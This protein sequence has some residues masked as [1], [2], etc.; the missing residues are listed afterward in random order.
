MKKKLICVIIAIV[1]CTSLTAPVAALNVFYDLNNLTPGGGDDFKIEILDSGAINLIGQDYTARIESVEGYAMTFFDSPEIERCV[2]LIPRT[3]TTVTVTLSEEYIGQPLFTGQGVVIYLGE[4]GVYYIE[5]GW[6]GYRGNEYTGEPLVF[7]ISG[8]EL[9]RF[10]EANMDFL[11]ASIP[12]E[13]PS[14]WAE[15]EVNAAIAAGL[16][17]ANLQKNYTKDVS[18]GDVA[19]MFINLIEKASGQSIDDFMK[20]KGVTINNNAFTDT[21]NKAVLAANALGIINGVGNNKF[22]PDGILSRAQIAAIINRVARV[23]GVN[24]EGYTH[25]FTDVKGHWVDVEL[26]WPVHEEII[27]GVGDNKFDPDGNLTTEQAIAITY[28]ALAPLSK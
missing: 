4:D 13:K 10:M 16:V 14:L 28:R 1:L 2:F 24:T 7:K 19:Q 17:P 12:A 15:A 8:N 6:G 11:Y 25:N 5:E 23:T 9:D 20:A 22:D 21:T 18:R 3:G 26:G 27:K